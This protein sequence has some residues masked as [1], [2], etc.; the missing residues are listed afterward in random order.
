M[1]YVALFVILTLS[2]LSIA[3]WNQQ[4]SG[5]TN[6]LTDVRFKTDTEG[7]VVGAS[8]ILKTTDGG[9]TWNTVHS[10][11][12]YL[13][14]IEI[15]TTKILVVGYNTSTSESMLLSSSNN[16]V[17]WIETVLP[18]AGIVND[19]FFPSSQI[20]YAAG[21]QGTILKTLNGGI[22]WNVIGSG[23]SSMIQ[24]LY[25]HDANHGFAVGGFSGG[26]MYE[27]VD[28]GLT[29]NEI[30]VS[31][32][33]FLQAIT[34]SSTSTGYAVG[35]DGDI[36]KTTDGGTSW[37]QQTPVQVYG[38]MDV[39]FTDN[40][41]GYIVGG[42]ASSAEIQKTI[43]GGNSWFSQSPGVSHGLIGLHFPSANTGFAVGD[44]GTILSTS[45]GGGLS[46]SEL[47]ST[48]IDIELFPNPCETSFE[49]Q[50]SSPLSSI[51]QVEII[52]G[53]GQLVY[54]E[55]YAE[56]NAIDVSQFSSGLYLVKLTIQG[57]SII[58][59]L[60]KK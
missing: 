26:Y 13:E 5:V 55:P 60:Y 57:Q 32:T 2:Q 35:W 58:R 46:I 10:S 21:S 37:T 17:S 29:W 45:N 9:N 7:Y 40:A 3:Q 25:F 4:S 28:G 49:F 22:T 50:F 1:K 14:A 27:T 8:R 23:I 16:G 54:S 48:A 47:P 33:S 53:N 30:T 18:S 11:S 20:G 38:N 36:F 31:A 44:A 19:I 24:S 42:S 15:T 39:Y 56:G 34:F 51:E 52:S 43:D 41:T 6:Q 59:K 12:F